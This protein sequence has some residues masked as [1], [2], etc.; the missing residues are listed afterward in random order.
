M[1]GKEGLKKE[2]LLSG[3]LTVEDT[4][5]EGKKCVRCAPSAHRACERTVRNR[6]NL[7]NDYDG[8]RYSYGHLICQ[9]VWPGG[10]LGVSLL[11]HP[12]PNEPRI[13]SVTSFLQGVP[14]KESFYVANKNFRVDNLHS[15]FHYVVTF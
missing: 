6:A 3:K 5:S 8:R 12:T 13:P 9:L 10:G 7:E 2:M 14:G 1:L 4:A 15:Q 11:S